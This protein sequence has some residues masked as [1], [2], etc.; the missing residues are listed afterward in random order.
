VGS[1]PTPSARNRLNYLILLYFIV[2]DRAYAQ[3]GAQSVFD[4]T[5]TIGLIVFAVALV[6]F[7]V[8]ARVSRCRKCP[9]G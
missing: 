5:D 3:S 8:A 9:P 2:S 1:N 6:I 4:D 7:F